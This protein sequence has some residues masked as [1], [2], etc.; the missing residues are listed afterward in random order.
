MVE[1]TKEYQDIWNEKESNEGYKYFDYCGCYG[2]KN[3]YPTNI[4]KSQTQLNLRRYIDRCGITGYQNLIKLFEE[5]IKL[6]PNVN[7]NIEEIETEE[8]EEEN[9][10]LT[11]KTTYN[12]NSNAAQIQIP[13]SNLE[14]LELNYYNRNFDHFSDKK[15]TYPLDINSD[16][17]FNEFNKFLS[18]GKNNKVFNLDKYFKYVLI[19]KYDYNEDN[20]LDK[21]DLENYVLTPM[22]GI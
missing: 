22:Y 1:D 18:E 19:K 17:I 11:N 6:P 5:K 9:N 16:G 21:Y 2:L 20:K 12:P 10:E 15:P 3:N 4:Y 14:G 7:I 8:T 13:S